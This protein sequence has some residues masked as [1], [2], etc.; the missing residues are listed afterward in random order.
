MS[1]IFHLIKSKNACIIYLP[2]YFLIDIFLYYFCSNLFCQKALIIINKGFSYFFITIFF[3]DNIHKI[4]L[5]E[6]VIIIILYNFD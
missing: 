1:K 6:N 4:I 5:F 2:I 3:P